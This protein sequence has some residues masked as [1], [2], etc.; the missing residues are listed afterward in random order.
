MGISS[1]GFTIPEIIR[2]AGR[3]EKRRAYRPW[4][5]RELRDTLRGE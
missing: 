5:K 3:F 1:R 4:N 2:L